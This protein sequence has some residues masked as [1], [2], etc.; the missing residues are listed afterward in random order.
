MESY[1]KADKI[2]LELEGCWNLRT[3]KYISQIDIYLDSRQGIYNGVLTVNN[4]ENYKNGQLMFSLYRVSESTFRGKEYTFHTDNNGRTIQKEIPTKI[5]I[6]S[7]GNF[8][9]WT[10]DETVTMQR[11]N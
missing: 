10:S 9:T 4:L 8:L 7:D 2:I 1:R 6:N 3:G 11:C 5:T